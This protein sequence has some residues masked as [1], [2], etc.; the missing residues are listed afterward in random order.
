MANL[1]CVALLVAS[2]LLVNVNG[3]V[4]QGQCP[5][6]ENGIPHQ[7]GDH[8]NE[9]CQ[10]CDCWENAYGCNQRFPTCSYP[11][12]CVKVYNDDGCEIMAVMEN[13]ANEVCDPISC[14]MVGK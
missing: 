6:D 14:W 1:L 9:G 10:M 7:P 13:Q 12:G 2:T 5:E 3:W 11:V 8:W 4:A